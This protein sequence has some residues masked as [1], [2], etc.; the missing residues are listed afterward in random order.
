MLELEPVRK[1]NPPGPAFPALVM[2]SATTTAAPLPP[3]SSWGGKRD[4]SGVLE[5]WH[6]VRRHQNAVIILTILGGIFGFCQTLSEPRIY[7]A[8]ATVEIQSLNDN[9][10]NMKELSPLDREGSMSSDSDIQTQVRI[11]QSNK[12]I[13]RVVAK[14]SQTPPTEPLPLP[15]RLSVWRKALGISP[16]SNK[17]LWEQALGSASGGIRVRASGVTRIVDLT[18]DSTS[19]Q[20]AADFVN[21]LASEYIEQNLETRF[22]STEHTGDWLKGQ[23]NDLRGK[24]EKSQDELQHYVAAQNL[25]VTSEKNNVSESKLADLQRE[26]S[27]AQSDRVAKQSTWEIASSSPSDSLPAILD[28]SGLQDS[29]KAVQD[30]RRNLAQ[31]RVTYTPN[32]PE[33][34][35]VE[36]QLAVLEA[37]LI[38]QR[39]S[40]LRRIRNEYDAAARREALLTGFYDAQAHQVSGE[41]AGMDRYNFLKREVDATRTLYDSILQKMKEASISSAL[42]ASNINIVDRADV[43]GGPYK[44]DVFRSA[45]SGLLTG[46]VLGIA[47]AVSRERADR[48]LQDPGDA[49]H[50]LRIPELGVIPMGKLDEPLTVRPGE[51]SA[52]DIAIHG[53]APTAGVELITHNSRTS[54]VAEAFRTT[55]TSILFSG[56]VVERSRI[57]VVTSA[58]PKEGKTTV[59]CN[60]SIALAEVQDRVLLIDCDMRRPRLH[61]VFKVENGPGLSDLLSMREPLQW[62]DIEGLFQPSG[63]PS[64][65][66]MTSGTARYKVTTLLYSQR[67]PELIQL[68]RTRFNT[69]VFDTPPMVNIADARLVGRYSDGVVL[70]VRSA[71]TTRD[72]ALLAKQRLN[73][74]GSPLL[75]L[76][77]NGWNPN[78]P[79]Y[80]YYRNYYA[81]YNHYYGPD[82][83]N[84]VAGE[85]T[86]TSRFKK[87]KKSA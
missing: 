65:S 15:D 29:Q 52:A 25:V 84:F 27:T 62:R 76:I 6:M 26:L 68:L 49:E 14:M 8:H 30:L 17:E 48:T 53:S 20:V 38:K 60:L 51:A 21:T 12:L 39:D 75:G 28:D 19:G 1:N 66:L 82:S 31:L 34:R 11:L 35:R 70:V 23:L 55:L 16:P 79:G 42:R 4:Y 33:V 37:P 59:T 67:L 7:Q 72:A 44:P 36:A 40:I 54:L 86:K 22:N 83:P 69:V 87:R 74:D 71:Y 18:C 32:H 9:F 81:G 61:T 10:L 80:S 50:Y 5:Y 58:S 41:T 24:L 78:V 57:L 13:R 47:Y 2:Q 73:E 43:P 85:K 64:L 56:G 45:L 3:G 46:L 63:V 77:M